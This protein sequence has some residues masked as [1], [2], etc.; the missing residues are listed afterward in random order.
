MTHIKRGDLL[1]HEVMVPPLEE[2][3]R[4]AE[5]LDTIDDT[6]R[7]TERIIEKRTIL[8]QATRDALIDE[9]AATSST[10]TLNEVVR[11]IDCKHYTPSTRQMDT[12]SC[13]PGTSSRACLT[14]AMSSM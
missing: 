13:D 10:Q 12:P 9:A 11:V 2:Q 14:S 6:I 4:I 8:T 5:V 3:R 1:K 7:A